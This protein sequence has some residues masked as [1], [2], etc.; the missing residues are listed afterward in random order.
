MEET[1]EKFYPPYRHMELYAW[2]EAYQKHKFFAEKDY[3][4]ERRI[5]TLIQRGAMDYPNYTPPYIEQFM[6]KDRYGSLRQDTV[7]FKNFCKLDE[8]R[9]KCNSWPEFALKCVAEGVEEDKARFY[10]LYLWFSKARWFGYAENYES[11]LEDRRTLSKAEIE[12]RYTTMARL[13]MENCCSYDDIR[14]QAFA[15]GHKACRYAR[16]VEREL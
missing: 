8:M 7:F 12:A 15:C 4:A 9:Q 5:R 11:Y 14:R 6:Y 3:A 13:D 1:S 2:S 10:L 16:F